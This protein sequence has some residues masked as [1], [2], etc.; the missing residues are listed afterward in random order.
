MMRNFIILIRAKNNHG[1][2]ENNNKSMIDN[3]NNNSISNDNNR[4]SISKC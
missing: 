2:F 3:H 4:I 1:K